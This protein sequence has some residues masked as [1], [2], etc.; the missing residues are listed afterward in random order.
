MRTRGQSFAHDLAVGYDR[1]LRAWMDAQGGLLSGACLPDGLWLDA[2]AALDTEHDARSALARDPS[3]AASAARLPAPAADTFEGPFA[4]SNPSGLYL[5][6]VAR[7][8]A[9]RPDDRW[10]SFRT[11]RA[12]ESGH[13]ID[14]RR[15][16]PLVRGL[17]ATLRLLGAAGFAPERMEAV[18]ERRAQLAA[19][20]DA[21]DPALAL[22]E[23][24]EMLP[25]FDEHPE[26]HAA[27]YASALASLVRE[28]WSRPDLYPGIDRSRRV[29]PQLHLLSDAALRAAARAAV[30]SG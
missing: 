12:H 25:V 21:P 20:I 3:L 24:V 9:A 28:V 5:R 26:V 27:G 16:L 14:I 30:G 15:H 23:M 11:L 2:D 4:L 17:P 10:G 29:L 18:L 22:A 1:A 19:M 8:V 6:L 13:V 7:Y